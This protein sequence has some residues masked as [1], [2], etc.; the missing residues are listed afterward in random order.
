M[1]LA[2]WLSLEAYDPGS[3][4]TRAFFLYDTLNIKLFYNLYN[5]I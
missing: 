2:V 3:V 1:T 4:A 5:Q